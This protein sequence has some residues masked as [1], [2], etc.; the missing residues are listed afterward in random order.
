MFCLGCFGCVSFRELFVESAFRI[1]DIVGT[2]FRDR[3]EVMD[4]SI[5]A[6]SQLIAKLFEMER[7]I[8]L[9]RI[10]NCT[11]SDVEHRKYAAKLGR[12]TRCE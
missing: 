1:K 10:S 8:G 3:W 6:D 12:V 5:M 2:F 4:E 11:D 7:L 9:I